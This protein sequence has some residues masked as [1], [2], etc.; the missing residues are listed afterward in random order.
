MSGSMSSYQNHES[1]R[2]RFKILPVPN[3]AGFDSQLDNIMI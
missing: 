1:L 2:N 3:K